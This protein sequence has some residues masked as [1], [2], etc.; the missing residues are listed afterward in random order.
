MGYVQQRNLDNLV[1]QAADQART[2]PDQARKTIQLARSMTQRLG[3]RGMT[4]ALGQ[5]AEELENSGAI[6]AGTRKTIKLGARTRTVKV[7]GPDDDVP[8]NVPPQEEIRRLTGV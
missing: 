3:N 1:R 7:G 6:S 8:Q 2:N 5:A 4:V